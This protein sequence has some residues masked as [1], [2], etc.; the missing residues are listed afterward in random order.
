MMRARIPTAPPTTPP[1]MAAVFE[2]DPP[3]SPVTVGKTSWVDR[4]VCVW[5]WPFGSVVT[6]TVLNT[7]VEVD[8]RI[9]E[10]VVGGGVYD[11]VVVTGGV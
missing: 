11:F 1:A 7:S 9:S 6:I 10:V 8:E 3:E 2:D 4:T 5:T